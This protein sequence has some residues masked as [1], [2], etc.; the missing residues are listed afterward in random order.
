M[1]TPLRQI[2]LKNNYSLAEVAAAVG[3]DAGNLSRIEKGN[4]S[5]PYN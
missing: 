4:Q 5:R 2:R 3:S 1:S